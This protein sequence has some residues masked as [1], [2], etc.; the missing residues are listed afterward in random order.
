MATDQ[1]ASET[2]RELQDLQGALDAHAIVAIT[3]A[4]GKIT[5][6]NEQF[7][8]ISQYTRAELLGQN[9][10]LISSGH[11]P[12]EFFRD[13]WATIARGKVWRGEIKNRAKDGSCYWVDTTIVPFLDAA[14]QPRKYVA[15]RTDITE[16]KRAEEAQ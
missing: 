11:H 7:C 5:H 10:R 4:Q 1:H 12:R 6:V 13:L 15:I 8:R 2:L 3:D 9:H 14:G 16:R